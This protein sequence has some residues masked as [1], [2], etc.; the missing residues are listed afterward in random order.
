MPMHSKRWS[1]EVIEDPV[2]WIWKNWGF[3]WPPM[4]MQERGNGHYL[5]VADEDGFVEI[6]NTGLP[7]PG[8]TQGREDSSM[9]LSE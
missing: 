3:S 8:T 2:L 7:V 9:Y 4:N 6:Y 1:V 5:V